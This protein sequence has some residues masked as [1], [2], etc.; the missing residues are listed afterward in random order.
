MACPTVEEFKAVYSKLLPDQPAPG[1]TRDPALAAAVARL[2][3]I[4][5][6]V[7]QVRAQLRALDKERQQ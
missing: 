2:D 3:E 4:A 1:I 5:G 7:T 6:L